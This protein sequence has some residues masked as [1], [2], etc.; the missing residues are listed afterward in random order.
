MGAT[1]FLGSV[2]NFFTRK[3]PPPEPLAPKTKAE[4]IEWLIRDH[5]GGRTI[6]MRSRGWGCNMT[7]CGDSVA[8]WSTPRLS[9]GD[10]V[11]TELG[12]FIAYEVQ[13]QYDPPDMV[14]AK[15]W[16]IEQ[17]ITNP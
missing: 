15:F 14:M 9:V 10:T 17:T 4:A 6:D 2:R 5:P 13:P 16:K 12:R 3:T 7:K 11:V 8:V 1:S